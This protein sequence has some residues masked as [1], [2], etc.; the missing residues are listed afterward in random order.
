MKRFIFFIV[1][2]YFGVHTPSIA[3]NIAINEDGTSAHSSAILE[4]K[5]DNK[6][7]LPP[8]LTANQ[9]TT[10]SAPAEGLV[11]YNL[12]T[13]CINYFDGTD[14]LSLC[15][16]PTVPCV[17][18]SQPGAISGEL[19]PQPL[20]TETYSI[21]PVL[22][23]TSYSWTVPIGWTIISGQGTSEITVITGNIGDDGLI[24]VTANNSCGN[25]PPREIS[26]TIAACLLPD[27]PG[28]ITG[29]I[30]VNATTSETYSIAPVSGATSYT[31]SVPIGWII[32]SG[33]GSTSIN[34]TTGIA[35]QNG[36]VSVVAENACGASTAQSLAVTIISST[37]P[38][39]FVDARDGQTY[40]AVEIGGQCWM[41]QNLNWAGHTNGNSFCFN[42]DPANCATLGR[43]YDWP[44][45]MN[46]A[47]Q[48]AA[49]PSG[50]QGSCPEGWHIPSDAEW[51]EL[52]L[53]L[54]MDLVESSAT[55][56][57]AT[58][59]VGS[60]IASW[61]LGG[62]NSSN[63]SAQQSGRKNI[64]LDSYHDLTWTYLWS[65]TFELGWSFAYYRALR[66]TSGAFFRGSNAQNVGYAVRCLKD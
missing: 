10:L 42:D 23:A 60:Q 61:S 29:E 15:G 1:V 25:S 14:W 44:A 52:E 2:F 50:V 64:V 56:W 28:S 37:C 4:L 11:V 32:N 17:L 49:N 53:F 46:G 7:F 30:L 19:M 45:A 9:I 24:A 8:R 18:P 22:G 39:S 36:S 26:V 5:S 48:S 58:G 40:E 54:G 38:S 12:T 65:A 6:G 35:G 21:A 3:Q 51:Q 63:F 34:V 33:Q 31:W 55:G 27:Q 57:R 66:P 62:T 47:T 13:Q 20:E 43:L 41:K 59:N 16:D